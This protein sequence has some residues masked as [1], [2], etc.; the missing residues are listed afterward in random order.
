MSKKAEPS[1]FELLEMTYSAYVVAGQIIARIDGK[2]RVLGYKENNEAKLNDYAKELIRSIPRMSVP[3]TPVIAEEKLV[4]PRRRR[5]ALTQAVKPPDPD[6]SGL[7][8][9]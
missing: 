2:H 6:L 9:L 8:D 4:T 1:D 3:V 7:D 5:S